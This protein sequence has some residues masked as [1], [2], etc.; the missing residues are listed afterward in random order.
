M[1]YTRLL[2]G[3]T[4]IRARIDAKKAEVAEAFR[5]FRISDFGI[6]PKIGFLTPFS[7]D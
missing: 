6:G 1:V 3:F 4:P 7:T 2:Q 5:I